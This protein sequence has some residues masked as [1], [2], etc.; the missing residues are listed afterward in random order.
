MSFITNKVIDY[1]Q[2]RPLFVFDRKS[3]LEKNNHLI[4]FS[5]LGL[6]IIIFARSW[7]HYLNPALY[8]EDAPF[9][10][11][12]SYNTDFL[13]RDI[14]RNPNGYYNV[15]NNLLAHLLGNF[16]VRVQPLTYHL[17]ASFITIFTT[18]LFC[19]IGLIKEKILVVL[20]PL[21]LGLSGFNHVY[22]YLTIT[23]QMYV[24]VVTL[25]AVLL[26]EAQTSSLKN[27]FIFLAI[28]ILVWSGP[29]SV[30][31]VPFAITF[32][33]LFRGKTVIM[34]WTIAVTVIYALSTTGSTIMLS[35]IFVHEFQVLWFKTL[36]KDIFLLGLLEH[37]NIEKVFLLLAIFGPMIYLIRRSTLHLRVLALLMVVIISSMAP[38]FLSKKYIMYGGIYPCHLLIGKFLWII[39]ILIVV[40]RL[41]ESVSLKLKKPVSIIALCL[42]SSFII[43]D[44]IKHPEMRKVEI[45]TN[46]P[47]F[48]HTIHEL[49][50]LH[51][52]TRNEAYRVTAEGSGIFTP[53]AFVGSRSPEAKVTR[54]FFIMRNGE[55]REGAV[56]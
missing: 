16:D 12:L 30:L 53:V 13:F 44:N 48:L 50:S 18:F 28:P 26:L 55:V 11:K 35:N 42:I 21:L 23:F 41:I 3:F 22:Y 10:F 15:L 46:V 49:E 36:V 56:P 29:Y 38:L 37:A 6:A 43:I 52:E 27:I 5:I 33:F 20:M 47:T 1:F 17:V 14:F 7:Q 2:N 51:I 40:D 24:L 8:A 39:F 4:W 32:I 34:L 31:A 54:N 25:F 9:Y 45:L 19:R